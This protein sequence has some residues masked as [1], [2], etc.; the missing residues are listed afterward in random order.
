MVDTARAIYVTEMTMP[1]CWV[2]NPML[3]AKL[4]KVGIIIPTDV[5]KKNDDIAIYLIYG[6]MLSFVFYAIENLW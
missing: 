6:L 1:N 3:V 2:D 4:G 5:P